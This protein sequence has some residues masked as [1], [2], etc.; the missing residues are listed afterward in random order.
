MNKE[1][2]ILLTA[3]DVLEYYK[4]NPPFKRL[5]HIVNYRINIFSDFICS[6]DEV[7]TIL[8]EVYK[9]TYI[10]ITINYLNN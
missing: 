8:G 6:T 7:E 1:D 4:E 5:V 2:L 9:W 10:S 3:L